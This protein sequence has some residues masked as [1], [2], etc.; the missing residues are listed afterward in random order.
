MGQFGPKKHLYIDFFDTLLL[1]SAFSYEHM[2]S[3]KKTR[4]KEFGRKEIELGPETLVSWRS[5][6]SS[7]NT[8]KSKSL[9]I[10]WK[11]GSIKGFANP[12]IH[13][14][15]VWPK[16]IWTNIFGPKN[17]VPKKN[18]HSFFFGDGTVSL[19]GSLIQCLHYPAL[20]AFFYC[21]YL[22]LVIIGNVKKSSVFALHFPSLGLD[23][24]ADKL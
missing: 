21:K 8:K 20:L 15:F 7:H 18:R 5:T 17:F 11:N 19:C 13:A 2:S 14:P 16:K 23:H 12:Y 10:F 3:Y 22:Q 6:H 24:W 9:S 4:S 1:L